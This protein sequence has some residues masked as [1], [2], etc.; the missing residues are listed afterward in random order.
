MRVKKRMRCYVDTS[1]WRDYF[2]ERGDRIK[3]LGE[4]G[5]QFLKKCRQNKDTIIVSDI[6][7]SELEGG[8]PKESV[9]IIISE[10]S[11]LIIRVNHTEKQ[12]REAAKM[13]REPRHNIPLADALH[14]IIARD[15]GAVLV[16]RDGHFREIGFIE[17]CAP[18]ELL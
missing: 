7:I 4:F 17:V 5:F 13:A 18:E 16:T 3:P 2:E 8:L 9:Q 14:A 11:D 15:E 10:F 6:I 12:F 1:V